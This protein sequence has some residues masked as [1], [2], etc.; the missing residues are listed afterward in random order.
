MLKEAYR[1][2]Y[3]YECQL[4][5]GLATVELFGITSAGAIVTPENSDPRLPFGST[6]H[7]MT[8]LNRDECGIRLREIDG[9]PDYEWNRCPVFQVL[10]DT[11]SLLMTRR[12]SSGSE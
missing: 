9:G 12:N 5:D 10:P 7:R 3:R 6:S 8:C 4:L 2:T 11:G 1:Q